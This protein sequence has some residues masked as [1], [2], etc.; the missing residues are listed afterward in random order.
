M[1]PAW[2]EPVIIAATGEKISNSQ[3]ALLFLN[4][5]WQTLPIRERSALFRRLLA[6]RNG[7]GT[8]AR[9][10]LAFIALV[11]AIPPEQGSL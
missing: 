1:T 10:R 9:A 8:H 7:H 4:R 3:E 6:A 2:T 5:H 11:K